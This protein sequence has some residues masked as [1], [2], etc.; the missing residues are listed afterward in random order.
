M[1]VRDLGSWLLDLGERRISGAFNATGPGTAGDDERAAR[2][3]AARSAGRA[4][5]SPGST[6]PS[7]ASARS[8]SGWSCRSGSRRPATRPGG[9]S[10][11]STSHGRSPTGCSFRPVADTVRDTLEWA[12]RTGDPGAPLASGL[13]LGEAGMKP[14]REAELLAEWQRQGGVSHKD[15]S[16]TPLSQKLGAKPGAGVVVFFTTSRDELERRFDGLKAT[17][18]PA[19]GLSVA[20]PKKAAKIE[21]D[22]DFDTV[23]RIGLDAA[24]STTSRRRSTSAGKRFASSTAWR[25][26][27]ARGQARRVAVARCRARGTA[28]RGGPRTRRSGASATPT[29]AATSTPGGRRRA[30]PRRRVR[31]FR[32][33]PS[34]VRPVVS[35]AAAASRPSAPSIAVPRSAGRG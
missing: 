34:S 9:A 32:S 12:L 25:T 3:R 33:R 11:R 15:Y 19:D 13:E 21:T 17:L 22:L 5:A 1:D 8:A 27:E 20:W 35:S 28:A 31:R 29:S 14:E 16:A 30:Q 26:G 7:C 23:Q 24:S 2:G 10:R 4:R 18:A 6:R